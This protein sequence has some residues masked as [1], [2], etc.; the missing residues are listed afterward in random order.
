V[1]FL[2]QYNP[3]IAV[4]H[5]VHL[6]FVYYISLYNSV[7]IDRF[8]C[9]GQIAWCWHDYTLVSTNWEDWLCHDWNDWYDFVKCVV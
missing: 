8:L 4:M 9:A 5:A 7:S 6:W 3:Y 2:P 1:D